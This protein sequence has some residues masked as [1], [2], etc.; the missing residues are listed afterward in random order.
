MSP[1]GFLAAARRRWY[2]L[3]AAALCTIAGVWA[4]HARAVS[5]QG[6]EVVKAV[7]P[8]RLQAPD[9]YGALTAVTAMV[10]EAMTSQQV[11]Q[12][13]RASGAT[14]YT[15]TQ[16]SIGDIRFPTY[17][18]ELRYQAAMYPA[19][20]VCGTSHSPQGVRE[21]TD[22]LTADF[23]RLLRQM[24]ASQ[25]VSLGASITSDRV[26]RPVPVPIL[27]RPVAAYLGVALMGIVGGTAL[28]LWTDRVLLRLSD[29]RRTPATG[30]LKG[31]KR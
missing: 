6:C 23:G 14:G 31:R 16:S 12:R 26:T 17:A 2:V 7:A 1:A 21:V 9:M 8:P 15:V 11:R 19:A 25:H 5:Y 30:T 27:G 10:T 13:V 29:G 3:V 24:Q 4:V 22:L 28:L 18:D 20:L